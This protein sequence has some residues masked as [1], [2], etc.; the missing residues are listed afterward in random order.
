MR[1]IRDNLKKVMR[2]QRKARAESLLSPDSLRR[3]VN[4]FTETGELPANRLQAAW[5]RQ[6]AAFLDFADSTV[7]GPDDPPVRAEEARGRYS[8]MI[9]EFNKIAREY[10][11]DP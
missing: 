2:A 6:W 9:A 10:G 11:I 1:R 4:R 8:Q 5:I 7:P 3:A